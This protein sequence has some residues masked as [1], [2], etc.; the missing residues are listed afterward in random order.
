MSSRILTVIPKTVYSFDN[1]ETGLARIQIGP[2]AIQTAD[3]K[4]GILSVCVFRQN[5]QSATTSIQVKVLNSFIS[6]EEPQTLFT[7][8][9]GTHAVASVTIDSTTPDEG[10]N[11]SLLIAPMSNIG[12]MVSVMLVCEQ[13][14]TEGQAE[15]GLSVTL[16]GRDA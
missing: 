5:I 8:S 3:W 1:K 2:R 15:V 14:A 10:E 12:A 4:S 9:I 16:I 13:G 6:P 11:G 7:E